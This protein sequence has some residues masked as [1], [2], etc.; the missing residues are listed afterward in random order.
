MASKTL[1]KI[2]N[3]LNTCSKKKRKKVFFKCLI[4]LKNILSYVVKKRKQKDRRQH[5]K[6]NFLY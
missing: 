6:I 2:Y 3:T 1:Q 5:Y 4:E